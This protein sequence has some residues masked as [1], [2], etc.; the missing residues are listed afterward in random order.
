VIVD[1]I[2]SYESIAR[3]AGFGV[4][5]HGF[6]AFYW[7]GNEREQSVYE[8]TQEEAWK[9]CCVDNKLV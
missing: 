9:A 3:E 8:E 6:N 1:S 5:Q 2:K 4:I 7:A